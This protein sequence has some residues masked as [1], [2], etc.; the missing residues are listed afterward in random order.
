MTTDPTMALASYVH[1]MSYDGLPQTAIANAKLALL[2]TIGVM[3]AVSEH[4]VGRIIA[5]YVR[6]SG[7][8]G[9]ASILATGI[10]TAPEFAALA[11][12]ILAHA[13]D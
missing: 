9:P 5:D 2:D 3:F 4:K 6:A 7:A 12:G 13:L 8:T 1:D 11:N 10:R